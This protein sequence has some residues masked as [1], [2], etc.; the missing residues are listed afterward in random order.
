MYKTFLYVDGFNLYYSIIKGTAYKWLD[1]KKLCENTF[2]KNEIKKA[3]YFTSPVSGS[4]DPDKPTRQQI[5]WRAL[6]TIPEL[7][8]IRGHFQT[9]PEAMPLASNPVQMVTVLKTEEKQTD[10]SIGAHLVNDAHRG[11]F[12][13]AIVLSNDSDLTEAIRIVK[14][15][16]LF[17][18]LLMCPKNSPAQEL[19]RICTLYRP[20]TIAALAKSLFPDEL[21]DSRGKFRKPPSW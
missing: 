21:E 10:V 15:E 4:R 16:L 2:P 7:E 17:P 9:N 14:D 3:K 8:I 19:R 5:Y 18:L 1:I 20:I 12:E 13:V 6:R 11:R